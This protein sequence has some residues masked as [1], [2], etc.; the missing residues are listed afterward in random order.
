MELR[1]GINFG[2][3]VPGPGIYR[4]QWALVLY[5]CPLDQKPAPE[6]ELLSQTNFRNAL[7][8]F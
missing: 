2:G 8:L 7:K 1:I 6:F 4:S 3:F 5:R